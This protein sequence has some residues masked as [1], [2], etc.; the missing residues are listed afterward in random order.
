MGENKMNEPAKAFYEVL[1][2]GKAKLNTKK[3]TCDQVD[4]M[5]NRLEKQKQERKLKQR[6]NE[7]ERKRHGSGVSVKSLPANLESSVTVTENE[8]EKQALSSGMQTDSPSNSTDEF[9]SSE[10]MLENS[11]GSL[12]NSFGQYSS[13]NSKEDLCD[14]PSTAGNGDGNAKDL[15]VHF[16]EPIDSASES[17]SDPNRAML[18]R[19][20][21]SEISLISLDKKHTILEKQFK[22]I[23]SVSQVSICIVLEK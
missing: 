23:A 4:K 11:S 2:L 9:S 16:N 10:N 8:L 20:G 14:C 12:V 6:E 5:C 13:D 18:F 17:S 22:D 19:L 21:G 1:Y 7:M 15:H 3:I